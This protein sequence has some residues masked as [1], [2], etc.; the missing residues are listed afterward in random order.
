[1]SCASEQVTG[2]V[3]GA[4][5][6]AT[7]VQIEAHLAECDLCRKQAEFE[8][9]L[10]ARL[11]RLPG[12]EP[13][14]GFEAELRRRI[15]LQ[16]PRRWRWA[17]PIAAGL[18]VLAF[19]GRNA[20][21]FVALEL[22]LDHAKCFSFERLPAEVWGGDPA[23]LAEWFEAKGTELPPLPPTAGGLSLVGGRYCPLLDRRAAHLY[24]TSDGRHLSVFVL[25]GRLYG[26]CLL[27]TSPSPRDRQ[28][29]R[30]PSSA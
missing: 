16:R 10:R 21:P 28:K 22:A 20:A 18:A 26:A 11:R 24:Y 6:D 1:M 17:L 12:P 30:M 27:Y 13:R 25:A 9:G 5:D 29:S 14:P 7:R 23:S 3:D 4:L 2:Y 8:R 15:R 19:W